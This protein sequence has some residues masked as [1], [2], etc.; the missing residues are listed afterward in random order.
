M[1]PSAPSPLH[2]FPSLTSCLL[3]S[4]MNASGTLLTA[5]THNSSKQ[6][7]GKGHYPL[8]TLHSTA[9]CSALCLRYN[10]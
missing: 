4:Y 9:H 8:A 10:L 6:Q 1:L 5:A 2:P 3:Q 7:T